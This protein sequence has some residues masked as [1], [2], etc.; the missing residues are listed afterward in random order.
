MEQNARG[1]PKVMSPMFLV[2]EE[3]NVTDVAFVPTK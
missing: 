3:D 1:W 2:D